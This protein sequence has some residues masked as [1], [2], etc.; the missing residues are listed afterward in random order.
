MHTDNRV[1]LT[2]FCSICIEHH[3]GLGLLLNVNSLQRLPKI[4]ESLFSAINTTGRHVEESRGQ[5]KK[6]LNL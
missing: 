4:C 1:A 5:G 6:W 3:L 2:F